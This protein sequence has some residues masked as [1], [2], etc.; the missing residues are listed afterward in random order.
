MQKNTLPTTQL[1]QAML[2]ENLLPVQCVCVSVHLIMQGPP[3]VL[4]TSIIQEV[5][6]IHSQ[7]G[8]QLL[9]TRCP[10]FRQLV[11]VAMHKHAAESAVHQRGQLLSVLQQLKHIHY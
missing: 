6:G 1:L 8:A 7:P 2:D 4:E 10:D 5:L 11:P 9:N 3:Q